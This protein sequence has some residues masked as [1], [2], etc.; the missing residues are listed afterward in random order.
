[1]PPI[2]SSGGPSAPTTI[3]P[4]HQTPLGG[5]TGKP[6]PVPIPRTANRK[7]ASNAAA[8]RGAAAPLS[9][10][11][12][13]RP[14]PN[15]F[16][17][18]Q[19][20]AIQVIEDNLDK[21]A[22]A[23][24]DSRERLAEA[25]A[26]KQDLLRQIEEAKTTGASHKDLIARLAEALKYRH[27]LYTYQEEA[28]T[29]KDS[30]IDELHA[31]VVT[32]KEEAEKAL[33]DKKLAVAERERL[34]G[35]LAEAAREVDAATQKQQQ[36][37][38]E[39]AEASAA[40]ERS[41]KEKNAILAKLAKER[42]KLEDELAKES[43]RIQANFD[44]QGAR[45][46]ELNL[47]LATAKAAAANQAAE[48]RRLQGQA[49]SAGN[50][51][52]LASELAASQARQADLERQQ[53]EQAAELAAAKQRLEELDTGY[54]PLR[55]STSPA[56][57]TQKGRV[58]LSGGPQTGPTIPVQIESLR[59]KG[60]TNAAEI[61]RLSDELAS[62]KVSKQSSIEQQAQIRQQLEAAKAEA[63]ITIEELSKTITGLEGSIGAKDIEVARLRDALAAATAGSAD[64]ARIAGQLE[65]A[66][67]SLA[68]TQSSHK[69]ALVAQ[70]AAADAA[71]EQAGR[72][73]EEANRRAANTAAEL[74]ALQ[75]TSGATATDL[76]A[77]R[78]ATAAAVASQAA[79]TMR[80]DAAEAASADAARNAA[81]AAT[82]AAARNAAATR[83]AAAVAAAAQIAD[84]QAQLAKANKKEEEAA[85][86]AK[87]AAASKAADNTEKEKAKAAAIAAEK[88]T[89][90]LKGELAVAK[91]AEAAAKKAAPTAAKPRSS[92][93]PTRKTGVCPPNHRWRDGQAGGTRRYKHKH[94]RNHK[95]RHRRLHAL[96]KHAVTKRR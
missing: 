89:K 39:A 7:S 85:E 40:A 60:I 28:I 37:E 15:I 30:I 47:Q 62:S 94:K 63:A 45:I 57:A 24:N 90:R 91:K 53:A 68:D 4:P 75:S 41:E 25:E 80:A 95:T 18:A 16:T 32:I 22:T 86:A 59:K 61:Q 87:T 10:T 52:R 54:S 9:K 66:Q 79:A 93:G 82:A 49:A 21:A 56:P 33:A 64:Q 48:T 51:A 29:Y 38:F 26:T 73:L 19:Q 74:A 88:E 77:A 35:V 92:I 58:R 71:A 44:K 67:A 84:L 46:D 12:S 70:Q 65:A 55:T 50:S 78:G 13:S 83:N 1:M 81:V 23:A 6:N 69:A 2:P 5:N 43:V 17:P 8:A 14:R 76:A 31:I 34:D 3:P 96:S 11:P 42:Q 27:S 72:L 20:A 36:S